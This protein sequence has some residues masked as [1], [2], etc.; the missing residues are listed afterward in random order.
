MVHHLKYNDKEI[1][2]VGTAHVSRDSVQVVADV[3]S[4]QRPDTV[5]IELCES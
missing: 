3:I 4:K 2:L 1:T 5:C